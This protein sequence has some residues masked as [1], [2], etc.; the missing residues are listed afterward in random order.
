MWH[1]NTVILTIHASNAYNN[2]NRDKTLNI[3]YDQAPG[4]YLAALDTYGFESYV[5][6]DEERLPIVTGTVQVV[7]ISH[8][9][10]QLC[11]IRFN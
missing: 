6:L 10:F 1:S 2:I 11:S 4:L 8:Y 7:T 3:I 5:L 9:I